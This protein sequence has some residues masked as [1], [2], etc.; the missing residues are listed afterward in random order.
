MPKTKPLVVAV[1]YRPP[2]QR[3]FLEFIKQADKLDTDIK[4]SHILDDFNI[5]MYQNNKYTVHNDSTISSK[6]LS[7][8]FKNYEQFCTMHDLK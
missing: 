8:D 7:S 4:E 2:N 5:N 6:L 3:N 1:I